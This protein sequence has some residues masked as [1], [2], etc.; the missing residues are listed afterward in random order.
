[1]VEDRPFLTEDRRLATAYTVD[2]SVVRILW[3]PFGSFFQPTSL[4]L[5]PPQSQEE[6]LD[7]FG[8][9]LVGL[10]IGSA[11]VI[12]KA[13]PS[14]TASGVGAEA[15]PLRV[16]TPREAFPAGAVALCG[17]AGSLCLWGTLEHDKLV[18]WPFGQSKTRTNVTLRVEGDRP[19]L[20]F[21][22]AVVPCRRVS[23]LLMPG[24]SLATGGELDKRCLVL[25]GW[26]G[27]SVPVAAVKLP[28][29]A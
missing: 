24:S 14:S 28:S 3:P 16:A 18:V 26:D 12:Y 17:S 6:S 11:T 10:L 22:G 5:L 29:G 19:W 15:V 25:A 2:S 13:Q 9:D 8:S 27:E 21:A 1:M 20:H 4:T 7:S 23:P